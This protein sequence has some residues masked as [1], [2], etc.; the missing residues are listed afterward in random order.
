MAVGLQLRLERALQPA[1]PPRAAAAGV[2]RPAGRRCAGAAALA[3]SSCSCAAQAPA[4]QQVAACAAAANAA[5]MQ[6]QP[7]LP[8]PLQYQQQAAASTL[9][10]M[11]A[12]AC[13]PLG[14]AQQQH[15][16]S[17]STPVERCSSAAM[18][19]Q[20]GGQ[21]A[22]GPAWPPQQ[23]ADRHGHQAHAM[24]QQQGHH[25]RRQQPQQQQQVVAQ[26]Q[27]DRLWQPRLQAPHDA[28]TPYGVV[29][30]K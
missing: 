2:V 26:Q 20:A 24:Q 29:W 10:Q 13:G 14:S 7:L 15:G 3:T 19:W 5:T 28:L 4:Q 23:A 18:E 8:Q 1:Q 9:M 30:H 21:P 12:G 22:L 11:Q 6:P 27:G 17:A 16:W 25:V